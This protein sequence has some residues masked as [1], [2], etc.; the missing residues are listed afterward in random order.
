MILTKTIARDYF[1]QN[2]GFYL[3]VVMLA[4]GFMS[5]NEHRQII[6]VILSDASFL[7][8]TFLLWSIHV[9][10]TQ[11]FL[12]RQLQLPSFEF[13]REIDLLKTS[14]LAK[15]LLGLQVSLNSP[16]ILY[17]AAMMLLGLQTHR[18]PQVI[19]LFFMQLTLL[20]IPAIYSFYRI[21]FWTKFSSNKTSKMMSWTPPNWPALY[22]IRHLFLKDPIL[23]LSSKAL[24]V[25]FVAGTAFLFPTDDY[26]VRLLY[27][28]LLFSGAGQFAI[29][30]S[31]HH[32]LHHEMLWSRNFPLSKSQLFIQLLLTGL[33]LTIIEHFVILRYWSELVNVIQLMSAMFF[34]QMSTV[35][36][37]SYYYLTHCQTDKAVRRIYFSIV[38]L[39]VFTMFGL[40]Y[41]ILGL[42]I[43]ILAYYILFRYYD[44]FEYPE[45]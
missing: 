19:L 12:H 6:M 29:G 18:I 21:R 23:F 10:K 37:L 5:W 31:F 9:L 27:L 15:E 32:F 39:F 42:V 7:F 24:S 43:A 33:S 16:F 13:L 36:W 26:D 17:G 28:G 20:V 41:G 38:F 1:R 44:V 34:I 40:P 25:F 2:I 22:F 4:F 3:L 35:F 8:Y 14:T 30:R 45:E 11:Y